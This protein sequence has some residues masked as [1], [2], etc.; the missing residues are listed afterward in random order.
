MTY[1]KV[2]EVSGV[3]GNYTVKILK[4]ARKINL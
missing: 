1:S 3:P 4:K 2:Q